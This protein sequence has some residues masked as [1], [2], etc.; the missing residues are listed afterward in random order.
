MCGLKHNSILLA[1]FLLVIILLIVNG[2]SPTSKTV[3]FNTPENFDAASYHNP[4]DYGQSANVKKHVNLSSYQ[5]S[6][7]PASIKGGYERARKDIE[8]P[9]YVLRNRIEGEVIVKAFINTDGKLTNL[10]V[11]KSSSNTLS[12]VTFNAVKTW[13]FNAA[14]LDGKPVKSF[15]HIPVTYKFYNVKSYERTTTQH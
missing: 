12:E 9:D 5:K 4:E 2:C 1:Q 13:E 3:E 8:V 14:K 11:V 6:F 15:V 7:V 10:K